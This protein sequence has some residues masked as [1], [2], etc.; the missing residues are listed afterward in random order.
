MDII[1]RRHDTLTGYNLI[2]W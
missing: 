2:Y 1:M